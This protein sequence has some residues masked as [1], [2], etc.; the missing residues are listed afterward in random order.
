M[1]LVASQSPRASLEMRSFTR[2]AVLWDDRLRQPN[3]FD[4]SLV[5]SS[6]EKAMI[7]HRVTVFGQ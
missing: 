2:R 5:K 6:L 4:S 1:N 7:L 3:V